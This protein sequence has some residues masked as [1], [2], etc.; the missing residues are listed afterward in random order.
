MMDAS[1]CAPS[2]ADASEWGRRGHELVD[3]A[4]DVDPS[5]SGLFGHLLAK[6]GGEGT[7][8]SGQPHSPR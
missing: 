2:L 8:G 6:E 7:T 4:V 5:L 3:Q 1:S